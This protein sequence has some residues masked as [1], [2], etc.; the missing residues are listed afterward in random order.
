MT[1]DT[2]NSADT[3]GCQ[4]KTLDCRQGCY[5]ARMSD[6]PQTMGQLL[7]AIIARYETEE[8]AEL[9]RRSGVRR[10]TLNYW[11]A[12]PDK[13]FEKKGREHYQRIF[14]GKDAAP[15]TPEELGEMLLEVRN[16]LRSFLAL[17]REGRI[18]ETAHVKRRK[19][20]GGGF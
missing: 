14:H 4:E 6:E 3:V 8:F 15:K 9:E 5:H 10:G 18:H 17:E 2:D 7:Q 11:K 13:P 20:G 12:H 19:A 16:L 1:V